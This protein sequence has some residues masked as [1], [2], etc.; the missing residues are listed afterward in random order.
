MKPIVYY[1]EHL[2]FNFP[3]DTVTTEVAEFKSLFTFI[4][5]SFVNHLQSQFCSLKQE[6]LQTYFRMSF[7]QYHNHYSCLPGMKLILRIVPSQNL[8]ILI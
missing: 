7:H 2:Y 5:N 8:L 3:L 6:D 4:Y 1:L